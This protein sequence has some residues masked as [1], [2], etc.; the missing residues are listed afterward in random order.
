M[1]RKLH[2]RVFPLLLGLFLFPL[3][4]FGATQ[5]PLVRIKDLTDI[6]GV[7]SNQ[8]VGMGLVVGLAGTGDKGT[9][10]MQMM[11]NM[12]RQYG[13]TLDLK[14]LKSKNV[15]V[16]SVTA[17]LPPFVTSGQTVDVA[18]AAVGDAK[19][20]QG[21]ILLQTPLKAANGSVYAVAQGPLLVGGYEAGGD[22]A[23]VKQ[24]V[25]TAALIPGGA[26]VERDVPVE[27][28]R[29]GE[30][31]FQLRNPDFTTAQ[32]VADTINTLYYNAAAPADAS[33]VRVRMPQGLGG[34]PS[35]FIAE[36]ESLEVRP[37]LPA[38]VVVNERTGTVVMGA[39]VRISTVAVAHGN[40]TVRI[41][42]HPEASQ[43]NPFGGGD[44][45]IVPD[46][47]VQVEEEEGRLLE[48]PTNS[49]V[50]ELVNA[51]NG[52]GAS[53]RDIIS[54]LQAVDKAGALYGE[55]VVQ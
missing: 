20:L 41:Q 27:L 16:V 37:D 15:A 52:V 33:R 34:N 47:D 23:S 8:L 32:R 6:Q 13:V 46:T 40:I 28:G 42:E 36:I 12:A 10:A 30:I 43:P 55:L 9:M 3:L 1:K 26:I 29:G 18:V 21:G 50:Q 4:A 25:T 22:A 45:V 5:H 38:K 31:I 44:T 39:D 53:P 48:I 2:N 51:L 54:I 49:N 14:S 11:R 17:A 7:R 24:N 35:R 19:S